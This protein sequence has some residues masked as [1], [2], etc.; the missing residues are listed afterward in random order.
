MYVSGMGGT[1]T[2]IAGMD[3]AGAFVRYAGYAVAAAFILLALKGLRTGRH[4]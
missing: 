1:G 3:I 2:P 4:R